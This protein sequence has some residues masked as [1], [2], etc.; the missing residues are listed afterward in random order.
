MAVA[1]AATAAAVVVAAVPLAAEDKGVLEDV[2]SIG[3]SGAA[4][5]GV[6]SLAIAI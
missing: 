2:A 6:L 4:V 1:V 5:G 3:V